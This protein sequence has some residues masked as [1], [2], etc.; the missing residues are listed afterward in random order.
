MVNT[1]KKEYGEATPEGP[2]SP[3]NNNTLLGNDG[4]NDHGIGSITERFQDSENRYPPCDALAKLREQLKK[5]HPRFKE[6]TRLLT[7]RGKLQ[8]RLLPEQSIASTPFQINP[9][10][11]D[12]YDIDAE[13]IAERAMMQLQKTFPINWRPITLNKNTAL[14]KVRLQFIGG[15]AE[16][17]NDV[18]LSLLITV[19]SDEGTLEVQ[20]RVTT[21]DEQINTIDKVV[22]FILTFHGTPII[23]AMSQLMNPAA[24]QGETM[25]TFLER[26]IYLTAQHKHPSTDFSTQR[27]RAM[28]ITQPTY[29]SLITVN[30]WNTL[31]RYQILDHC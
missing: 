31:L 21:R 26:L 14:L 18:F 7:E 5:L 30:D 12:G 15:Y 24:K 4:S 23:E 28:L 11:D 29:S 25:S 9:S 16:G 3:T 6:Q 8:T 2:R 22:E 27:L 20:R 13:D 19:L 1:L 17:S 10:H